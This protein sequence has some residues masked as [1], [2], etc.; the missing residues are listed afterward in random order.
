MSDN[1]ESET[2]FSGRAIED[3]LTLITAQATRR[4]MG[5][6]E[7]ILME[8]E[9]NTRRSRSPVLLIGIVTGVF[10]LWQLIELRKQLERMVR[11][12]GGRGDLEETRKEVQRKFKDENQSQREDQQERQQERWFE[13]D[14]TGQRKVQQTR[15]EP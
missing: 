2:M 1:E 3:S 5:R 10:I 7:I 13:V 8:I 9:A 12:S 14:T 6:A 15:Q 4:F 11:N